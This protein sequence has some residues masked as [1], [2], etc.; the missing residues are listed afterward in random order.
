MDYILNKIRQHRNIAENSGK[1]YLRNTAEYYRLE[2]EYSCVFLLGYLWNK[3]I[4]LI[5]ED[6][7][8]SIFNQ[9][10][11]PSIGTIVDICRTLD[12]KNEFF[13]RKHRAQRALNSYPSLR[14]KNFGHG[15]LFE[16]TQELQDVVND[17]RGLSQ[18]LFEANGSILAEAFH[19]ILVMGQSNGNYH[20]YRFAADGN[21]FYPWTCSNEIGNFQLNNIYAL[22]DINTN[23]Y[24]RLSPF[25]VIKPPE[26]FYF[27]QDIIE[28][29]VGRARY[30]GV[31]ISETNESEWPDDF[32]VDISNDGMKRKSVNNTILNDYK[33]NYEEF[34]H[35][36]DIGIIKKKI[37]TFL[38]NNE[39]YVCAK[40]WGHGGVGKTATVQRVCEELSTTETRAFDYIVFASAKNRVYDP[41]E[42]AVSD[43]EAPIDSYAAL[44]KCINKTIGSSNIY[45]GD[46]ILNFK[47]RLLIIIDD[48]E[49][50]KP[51]DQKKIG[52]FI[53]SLNINHHKVILTT[54][55][56]VI[57]QGEEFPT[58]EL[59]QKETIKFLI[60]VMKRQYEDI[61]TEKLDNDKNLQQQ[62]FDVTSGRP[63]FIFQFAHLWARS[64]NINDVVTH[65]F[66]NRDDA[67]KFLYERVFDYL[68]EEG[69]ILFR[70]ISTLVTDSDLSNMKSKLRYIANME[71]EEDRF[72]N[73]ME[74]LI[75]LR[76][77]ETLPDADDFFRVYSAEI[78]DRMKEQFE[79]ANT[80]WRNTILQRLQQVKRDKN[81]DMEQSLLENADEKRYLV[82]EKEVV[83]LYREILD[84]P[85]SPPEIRSQAILNLT[86]YLS[87]DVGKKE[88]AIEVFTLYQ[89]QDPFRNDPLVI[90]EFASCYWETGRREEAITTLMNLL[91]R[92]D[93]AWM[94]DTKL[95]L[96]GLC[97]SYASREVVDLLDELVRQDQEETD[98]KDS[99]KQK[100]DLTFKRVGAPLFQ[101]V[102]DKGFEGLSNNVKHYVITGLY[103]FS[104]ACMRFDS[105]DIAGEI[106]RFGVQNSPSYK[107]PFSTKLD[108]LERYQVEKQLGN[109]ALENMLKNFQIGQTVKGTVQSVAQ[110]GAFVDL[111]GVHGLLHQNNI[112]TWGTNK[113][114]NPFELVKVGDEIEVEVHSISRDRAKN[115]IEL[116][117]DHHYQKGQQLQGTVI[118]IEHYGCFIKIKEG[119]EGLLHKSNMGRSSLNFN[120][121]TVVSLNEKMNV[122]VAEIDT[123]ERLIKFR[124]IQH[125]F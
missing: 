75:K 21:N 9:I 81:F 41:L 51:A 122:E 74:E 34:G 77:I 91:D 53:S 117:L 101:S 58:D 36:I 88:A 5:T 83:K 125:R 48:Y 18:E 106:C 12:I 107:E 65:D 30:N 86:A 39:A 26:Q 100:F 105:H 57:I 114:V 31:L 22:R 24:V 90:K 2:F 76:V 27:F 108:S 32:V 103:H 78:L 23:D 95:E 56:N 99:I 50:F 33:N 110:Y 124:M 102:K 19:L 121:N 10:D 44:L 123:K 28:K 6:E 40:V 60:D 118:R 11:R 35:Y 8:L 61:Q 84:R 29:M 92:R 52:Q 15:F 62:I 85:A 4:T 116:G 120:P 14:N 104:E 87:G 64:G 109:S 45:K 79:R 96:R 69:Q 37:K 43:I 73:G 42:G 70:T 20:G 97:L 25:I 3:N 80:E 49:T 112:A 38:L 7:R 47:G 54:R 115:R 17:L 46:E 89:G 113:L 94:G 72:N 67:I 68:E 82:S 63:L 55:A 13:I 71:T 66:K 1:E 59:S 93:I 98:E 119:V 111:G 16:D